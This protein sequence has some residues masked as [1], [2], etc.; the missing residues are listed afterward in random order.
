M[1]ITAI[2]VPRPAARVFL[3]EDSVHHVRDVVA[4]DGQELPAV[5]GAAGS[6]EKAVAVRVWRNEEVM[7]G[8][9]CVPRSCQFMRSAVFGM[10][11]TTH[12][13]IRYDS[14]GTLSTSFP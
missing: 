11:S 8:G 7:C 13:Q 3:G 12:Q 5:K 4:D 1:A 9:G 14:I 10:P 6:N 2:L